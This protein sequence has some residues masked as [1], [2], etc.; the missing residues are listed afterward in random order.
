[1]QLW[2]YEG[3]GYRCRAFGIILRSVRSEKSFN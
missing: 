1:M 3:V 2:N